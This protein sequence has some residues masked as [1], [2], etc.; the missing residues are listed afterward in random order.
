MK[1]VYVMFSRTASYTGKLIRLV[2]KNKYNHI[3]LC[4]SEEF[5]VLYSFARHFNRAPFY[6]GLVEESPLRYA[7]APVKV[8]K[9]DIEDSQ[10]N[11]IVNE[12]NMALENK[13]DYIYNFL[14]AAVF[15]FHKRVE[16]NSAY[17]CVEFVVYLLA[18]CN[19]M[20]L[21]NKYYSIVELEHLFKDNIVFEDLMPVPEN[22]RW[23]N[24]KFNFKPS[25]YRSAKLTAVNFAK[26]ARRYYNGRK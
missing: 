23:G 22:A 20:G 8:C 18:K 1:S 2:T 13:G 16:I 24:D 19:I 15:P 14:S 17:T 25:Y 11:A 6:G 3:S 9:L 5:S 12:L 4:L 10:Y 21:E 26:L 7:N